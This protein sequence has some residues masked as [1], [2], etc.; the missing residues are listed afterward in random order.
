ML[1]PQDF[2]TMLHI[3]VGMYFFCLEEVAVTITGGQIH[4]Y[5]YLHIVFATGGIL[6]SVQNKLSQGDYCNDVS[7]SG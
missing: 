6:I 2:G 7:S 5:M 3:P 4:C 1:Y